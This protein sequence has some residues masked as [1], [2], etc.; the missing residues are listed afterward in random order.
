[1]AIEF[2]LVAPVVLFLFMAATDLAMAVR[3]NMQL[4]NAA[5]AGAEYAA[6]HGW[7]SSAITSAVTS[8]TPLSVTVA[9]SAYCGCAT[10]S[11]IAEQA[12]GT[13]CAS[14]LPAGAYVKVVASATYRP[15]IPL[16]WNKI[17]VSNYLN[18]SVTSVTR[19][20]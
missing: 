19:T 1:M 5:R 8:A 18:M 15:L 11:N 16:Q 10:T 17:L 20:N 4:N 12:C 13:T 6:M 14:G 9:P 2:A 7:D 3:A